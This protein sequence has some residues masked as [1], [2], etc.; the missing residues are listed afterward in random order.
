METNFECV[1][2]KLNYK[3]KEGYD[4]H[5]KKYHLNSSE[6]IPKKY[7]CCQCN[8]EFNSRQTKWK[9]EQNCKLKKKSL[10]QKI[11]EISEKL[12]II[13]QKPNNV[14]NI[15][16]TT[17]IQY[18][19]NA[20]T[21][22][23]I[24]HLT[25][26]HQKN[27]LNKG[28][29]SLTYLIESV[30]FN[31]S[32]PE[33]HSYCV[34]AINDKHASVIDEKTNTIVKTNKFDLYDNVLTSHLE[35]LEQISKNPK[36]TTDEKSQYSEKIN[37]LKTAMYANNKF[38]KRYHTDINLISYNNKDMIKKTWEN[39]KPLNINKPEEFIDNISKEGDKPRGFDDLIDE[40]PDEEK[41]NWIKA[42]PKKPIIVPKER[43]R[44]VEA[45]P[46]YSDSELSSDSDDSDTEECNVPEI[47]IKSKQ[48]FLDGT[49]VYIKNSNGS[50]G[51]LY[52]TYLNNKVK[53]IVK[54]KE[55]D[56]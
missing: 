7:P 21:S 40:L 5:N 22:S 24:A 54:Q 25:F 55:F 36:F 8:K 48:Y 3:T 12:Q 34:T 10:E 16:N 35:L 44:L 28:L 47:T 43:I 4:K 32:V 19:I 33:N 14:T 49:N 13:E 1:I 6:K 46:D 2:C 26:E 23:S 56:L 20:P 37:Y 45:M 50:R 53:K 18:V 42:K 11:D 17:N 52:G 27:I 39:L 15:T 31:K 38:K 51:E 30:N 29:N 9:H 41:P